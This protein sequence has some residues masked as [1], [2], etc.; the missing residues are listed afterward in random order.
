[1]MAKDKEVIEVFKRK[2]KIDKR[3]YIKARRTY[4]D[5]AKFIVILLIKTFQMSRPIA[6]V[7]RSKV[8]VSNSSNRIIKK[9]TNCKEIKK[10][11]INIRIKS[12]VC[13]KELIMNKAQKMILQKN[14]C[15]Q[16]ITV[17]EAI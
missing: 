10:V 14:L 15:N 4:L 2:Y 16:I 1:M 8:R 13:N 3:I 5:K 12:V 11:V 9:I 7:N 17:E 6:K